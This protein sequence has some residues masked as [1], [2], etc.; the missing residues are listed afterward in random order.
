MGPS[1]TGKCHICAALGLTA[2]GQGRR[3]RFVTVVDL[4]TELSEAQAEHGLSRLGAQLYR[5]D[6]LVLD[7]PT[8]QLCRQGAR[9]NRERISSRLLLV[10]GPVANV[11]IV[12]W[13]PGRQGRWPEAGRGQV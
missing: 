5:L 12:T 11:G 6:L 4:V 7:L 9:T 3:V 10:I 8:P 13:P 2:C 1:G